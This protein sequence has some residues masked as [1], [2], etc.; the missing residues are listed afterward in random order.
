ML[1]HGFVINCGCVK[2]LAVVIII[3]SIVVRFLCHQKEFGGAGACS[4]WLGVDWGNH[5][6]DHDPSGNIT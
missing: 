5:V 6:H 4:A 2:E 1:G 3:F